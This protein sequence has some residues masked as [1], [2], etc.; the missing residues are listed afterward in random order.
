MILNILER[1]PDGHRTFK[2]ESD[3]DVSA[4]D[5]TG[6]D[7]SDDANSSDDDDDGD[8]WGGEKSK[9]DIQK[10][11]QRILKACETF[12]SN[13]RRSLKLWNDGESKEP[14]PD[15]DVTEDGC[16]NITSIRAQPHELTDGMER[17]LTDRDIQ[18]LCPG[19]QLKPYQLV[20][21]N[22]LKLLHLNKINGVLAG[23][24]TCFASTIFKLISIC[25]SAFPCAVFNFQ[26]IWGLAR[27][28]SR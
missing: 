7:N 17:V 8:G 26:T 2:S 24:E 22:W 9:G 3:A 27:Q 23:A 19:L 20:G 5:D 15:E 28:F 4:D 13:L 6:S 12:S 10:E 14:T 11:A 16:L 18:D 1:R 21:V 25:C